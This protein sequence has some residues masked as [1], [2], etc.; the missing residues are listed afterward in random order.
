MSKRKF[1][2][3]VAGIGIVLWSLM[4]VTWIANAQRI[5]PVRVNPQ[6]FILNAQNDLWRIQVK[7]TYYVPTPWYEYD[8]VQG[9][10]EQMLNGLNYDNNFYSSRH[11]T[12]SVVNGTDDYKIIEWDKPLVLRNLSSVKS[13]LKGFLF[14]YRQGGQVKWMD[15][16]DV[17]SAFFSGYGSSSN[18]TVILYPIKEKVW[19][20]KGK[21][22]GFMEYPC[23]N[24]VCRDTACS[25][26][27]P[28]PTC[29]DG[30]LNQGEQCDPNDP[31]T[32]N[33]CTSTCTYK[34]LLCEVRAPTTNF[35][36][37]TDITGISV[38]AQSP[39][40]INRVVVN[41][42]TYTNGDWKNIGK[43]PSGNYRVEA[44]G[45]NPYDGSEVIC[46]PGNLTVNQKIYCGDGIK[47]GNEECD[48]NDP[49]ITAGMCSK[50]CKLS[51]VKCEV[52]V[53]PKTFKQGDMLTASNFKITTNG[54]IIDKI[55]HNKATKTQGELYSQPLDL[56]GNHTTTFYVKNP[57]SGVDGKEYY[58]ST[59]FK[60]EPKEFCWDGIVQKNEQCDPK[61][62]TTGIACNSSCELSIPTCEVTD[63][64]PTYY[65]GKNSVFWISPT[66]N[67]TIVSIL[68]NDG[69]KWAV[70]RWTSNGVIKFKTPWTKEVVVWVKN[71]Y[72]KWKVATGSCKVNLKVEEMPKCVY[73][74]QV[75]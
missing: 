68:A 35:N 19:P 56:C 71:I 65:V 24:L 37:T 22:L 60:V 67:A 25:D 58:C 5:T 49:T 69:T 55:L 36:Q 16:A 38:S 30:I 63:I 59:S 20:N 14:A 51:P 48:P 50:S 26:L 62:S 39:L 34:K 7:W 4:V 3:F 28:K 10:K 32:R 44:Y 23:G 54:E 64:L 31:K 2:S 6:T 46:A 45:T 74:H 13:K 21:L 29:W 61:D 27:K 75:K 72:D 8:N 66:S 42:R 41:G 57:H 11:I 12:P 17:T 47:N 43:L 15:G 40:Q 1:F 52:K 73:T 53:D 9:L 70:L 33:G 18:Q